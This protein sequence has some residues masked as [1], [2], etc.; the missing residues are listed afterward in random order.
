MLN[1]EIKIGNLIM[2]NNHPVII[3]SMTNTKT[4]DI[5]AT[6]KQINDL[7]NLGAQMVR[8]TIS[9]EE[10]AY[11]IS[12]IKKLVNVPLVADIHFNYKL[13]IIAAKE[14]IDK[15]RI[16]PGNIGSIENI[17]AVTDICKEKNIPIRIGI[18]SG[19]L[20]KDLEE[21]YHR[22]TSEALLESI[23]KNVKILESLDFYNIVLS[24]KSTDIE[25][26]LA[27]NR[28][29]KKKYPYPIH[30]GLTESGTV[31]SGTI[32]SS[33]TLATLLKE[34]IGDTIRVS[35][36][37]DP[38]LEIPVAKEIL[39]MCDK[40]QKPTLICCPT[41]GRTSYKM[42]EIISEIEPFL[43]TLNKSIKVA[44]MGCA[45]NGPGEAKD[46]DIGIAGGNKE[47]LLFKKGKVIRKIA[48]ENIVNE[49]K[50]EILDIIN[51]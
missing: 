7:A 13:A 25:T 20:E 40:Y 12:K 5:D 17:K 44:I 51:N 33:Y 19:S 27:V 39:A 1:K 10:D 9:D 42:E 38:L 47:A 18:N 48:E 15:I 29:L 14:G 21:K 24:V 23:E 8:M 4:K 32:R 3:Q 31:N 11:A 43:N 6:A 16:N 34:N 37:G 30:I 28:Q 50:K 45:V 49:L 41:C 35:L 36:T 26:T 2:G 22:S 46:A